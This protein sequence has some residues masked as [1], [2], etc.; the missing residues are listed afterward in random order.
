VLVGAVVGHE[1]NDHAQAQ[2]GGLGDHGV[3]V[4]ERAEQGVDVAVITDVVAR[5]AL[6]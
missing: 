5:I 4:G 3:E 2:P 6:R 1:V